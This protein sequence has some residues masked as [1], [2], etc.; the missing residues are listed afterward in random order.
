MLLTVQINTQYLDNFLV[1][2]EQGYSKYGNPYHNLVHAAD[3]TQT[4]HSIITQSGLAVSKQANMRFSQSCDSH[5]IYVIIRTQRVSWSR[6]AGNDA[7]S[8]LLIWGITDI[9]D[10]FKRNMKW[11][12][13]LLDILIDTKQ[14][15]VSIMS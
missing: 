3:V 6:D 12:Q 2:M 9:N 1:R 4:T 7:G 5:L 14:T 13:K 8:L 11:W 15:I 10:S